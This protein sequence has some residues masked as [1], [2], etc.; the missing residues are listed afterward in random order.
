MVYC[1]HHPE[2]KSKKKNRKNVRN[3][4]AMAYAWRHKGAAYLKTTATTLK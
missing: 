1:R 3:K 4:K 2:K